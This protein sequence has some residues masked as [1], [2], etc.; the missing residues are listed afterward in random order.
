MKEG[1]HVHRH[2]VLFSGGRYVWH[3]HEHTCNGPLVDL[4]LLHHHA[5]AEH[6]G[7]SS[8]Q[9]EIDSMSDKENK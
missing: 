6:D 2:A 5:P 7:L 9:L 8:E 3:A 4:N 1:H